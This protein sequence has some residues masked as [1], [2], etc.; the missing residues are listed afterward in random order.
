MFLKLTF[1]V[2]TILNFQVERGY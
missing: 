2:D 1:V